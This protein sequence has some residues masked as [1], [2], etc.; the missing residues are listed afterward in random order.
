MTRSSAQGVPPWPAYSAVVEI[1]GRGT[2]EYRHTFAHGLVHVDSTPPGAEIFLGENS[3]GRT[4]LDLPLPPGAHVLTADWENQTSRPRKIAVFADKAESVNFDF[5]TGTT[6]SSTVRKRRRA[7]KKPESAFT[8]I[9]RSLKN[10][11][12]SDKSKK[13]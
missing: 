6:G 11:F 1:G 10:I 13:R 5:R 8:K 9:G 3:A 7:P 4:P 2:V 12:S